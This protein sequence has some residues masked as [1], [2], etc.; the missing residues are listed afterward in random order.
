MAS[1]G[2]ELRPQ[3]ARGRPPIP[4]TTGLSSA[5]KVLFSALYAGHS[6][7]HQ[8]VG[9]LEHLDY[10]CFHNILGMSSSQLTN[11][12]IFQRG[13]A[14]N[15][16]SIQKIA[17]TA[18]FVA[19]PAPHH[20]RHR[21]GRRLCRRRTRQRPCGTAG[22]GDHRRGGAQGRSSEASGVSYP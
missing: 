13:R 9:G 7:I 21:R 15:H 8:L 5:Q 11:S 4:R 16:S 14:K 22:T 3:K 17:Q 18:G 19:G 1:M 12:I 6:S 20:C 10:I 2:Q